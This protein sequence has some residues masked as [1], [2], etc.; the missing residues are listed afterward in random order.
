MGNG[1]FTQTQHSSSASSVIFSN[2]P[3]TQITI[4][5]FCPVDG[6][7]TAHHAHQDTMPI[8][9][10]CPSRLHA[11]QDSMPIKQKLSFP[12]NVESLKIAGNHSSFATCVRTLLATCLAGSRKHQH[13]IH[14]LRPSSSLPYFPQ[15]LFSRVSARHTERSCEQATTPSISIR[16]HN[17]KDV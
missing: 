16:S 15:P 1:A 17:A 12:N 8:K 3:R 14:S 9:T 7:L 6:T 10:P 5:S 4:L 13:K 2:V 11:H